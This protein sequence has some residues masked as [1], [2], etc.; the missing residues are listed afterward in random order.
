LAEFTLPL[1]PLE[2]QRRIA[3][4]VESRLSLVDQ[5]ETVID[6]GLKRAERLRQ[7]ILKRGFEGRL[8]PQDPTDEPASELLERIQAECGASGTQSNRSLSNRRR[9]G[10][11]E[12]TTAPR[13]F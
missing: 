7:A 13:L 9:R 1:P 11:R 4:E 12:L 2:E 8:V 3:A 6:H 10:Q 5:V